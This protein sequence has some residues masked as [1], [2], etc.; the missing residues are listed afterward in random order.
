MAGSVTFSIELFPPRESAGMA[1]F[2]ET[3][4]RLNALGPAFCSVT[5][6]AGGTTREGTE[7]A[8][9]KLFDLGV[10]SPTGHLTCAG[11]GMS[12]VLDTAR[13]WRQRGI[14]HIVALRGDAA[15]TGAESFAGAA[16]LVSALRELGM[17]EISVACYPEVH[18][19]SAGLAADLDYLK[20]KMDAGA[21]RA[22]SQLFFDPEV[23]L[24]F[25]DAAGRRG[26]T[27]PLVPGILPI[28]DLNRIAALAE[29]CGARMPV[30][31]RERLSNL[32]SDPEARG[33]VAVSLAVGLC[34][35]LIAEGVRSF[36]FYTLNRPTMTL[37]ICRA[38]GIQPEAELA[39]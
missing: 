14:R 22:L 4:A 17:P 13:R 26:I 18:P 20:R 5:Y 10:A 6:G 28:H 38:I 36:H 1:P 29:K 31:V 19:K 37:A 24:R 39:A 21:T 27:A 9:S 34:E 23:F 30:R 3:V 2:V 35:R 32:D 16:E 33:Q 7:A 8:L 11:Q 25:R 15:G 12:G